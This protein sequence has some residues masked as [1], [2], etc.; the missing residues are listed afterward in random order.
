MLLQILDLSSN[1]L[2]LRGVPQLVAGHWPNLSLLSLRHNP[3]DNI[4]ASD[5][6]DSSVLEEHKLKLFV[7]SVKV[8]WPA[9][10]LWVT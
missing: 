4:T 1:S 6:C 10:Q 8:K 7:T 9:V 3:L 2:S 5:L